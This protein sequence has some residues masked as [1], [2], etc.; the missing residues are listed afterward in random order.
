MV[1]MLIPLGLAL[2][3]AVTVS[4]QLFNARQR[5]HEL[6]SEAQYANSSAANYKL[7]RDVEC[8]RADANFEK[9]KELQ[10]ELTEAQR[11][12]RFV[13]RAIQGTEPE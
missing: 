9:A 1:I 2:V 6:T 5:I 13:A 10:A 7:A 4:I 8:R 11:R 3:W 12:L